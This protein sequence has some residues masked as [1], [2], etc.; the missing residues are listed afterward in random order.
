MSI[1]Y[2]LV[3]L[4]DYWDCIEAHDCYHQD[5]A[6]WVEGS[7]ANQCKCQMVA[8]ESCYNDPVPEA[9]LADIPDYK[10]ECVDE[11]MA[12]AVTFSVGLK[13]WLFVS[14]VLVK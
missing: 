14:F 7:C 11:N 13:I 9:M 1:T 4:K 3:T 6:A 8:F 10:S 12:S 2:H 5:W